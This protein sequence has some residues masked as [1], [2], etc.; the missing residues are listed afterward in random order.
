MSAEIVGEKRVGEASVSR[1][2]QSTLVFS[3]TYEYLVYT[4]NKEAKRSEILFADGLP[5][6]G[7]TRTETGAVCTSIDAERR[8][9]N[10]H[11]WDVTC[12]FETN[13]E[14][15]EIEFGNTN[16]RNPAAWVP[17]ARVTASEYEGSELV[18]ESNSAGQKF[19]EGFAPKLTAISYEFTQF[20]PISLNAR[21]IASRN[22]TS[23]SD[24]FP[25]GIE[26]ASGFS[27]EEQFTCDVLAAE[28]GRWYGV[29]LWRVRYRVT[30]GEEAKD[31]LLDVGPTYFENGKLKTFREKGLAYIGY[32]DGAGGALSKQDIDNENF[33]YVS[34]YKRE[35]IPWST[36]LRA[37]LRY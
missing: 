13:S 1:D 22:N 31:F 8:E 10:P 11:Y 25:L 30:Y 14:N 32:L 24:S 7:F 3:E 5:Y 28:R 37:R 34:H 36:W 9:D 15:F 2:E 4:D 6:V 18:F 19:D 27:I 16:A 35:I 33:E 23:N 26:I 12:E 20:E 21:D 17:I 29:D